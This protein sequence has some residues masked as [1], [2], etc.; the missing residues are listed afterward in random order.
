MIN[1]QEPAEPG[2]IH[3]PVEPETRLARLAAADAQFARRGTAQRVRHDPDLSRSTRRRERTTAGR[4]CPAA[5]PRAVRATPP[6]G[7]L[8][9]ASPSPRALRGTTT[10][11][12]TR[13]GRRRGPPSRSGRASAPH[14]SRNRP[15]PGR[16][17]SRTSSTASLSATDWSS[18]AAMR[19]FVAVPAPEDAT[20]EHGDSVLT[21]GATATK[22][23]GEDR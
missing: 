14:P 4:S 21:R 6:A 7:R 15:R 16:R 23:M 10:P 13:R 8:V 1:V 11:R 2:S 19:A 22:P 3:Q 9:R 18:A 17:A 5:R 20:P 12:P